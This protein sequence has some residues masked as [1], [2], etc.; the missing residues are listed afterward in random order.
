[1]AGQT[2][3]LHSRVVRSH[4]KA[5]VKVPFTTLRLPT[6]CGYSSVNIEKAYEAVAAGKMCV[7]R[8]AEEYGVPKSTLHDRVSG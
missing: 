8:A 4:S 3:P 5:P 1:M 7:Q 6:Y 2:L